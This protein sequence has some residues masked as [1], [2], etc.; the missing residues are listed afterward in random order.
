M[1]N[2][3]PKEFQVSATNGKHRAPAAAAV[4]FKNRMLTSAA[5][6]ITNYPVASLGVALVAGMFVGRLVKR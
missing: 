3:L 4:E 6:C 5:R 1:I 2:R